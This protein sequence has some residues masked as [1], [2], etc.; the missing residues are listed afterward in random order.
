MTAPGHLGS[1][2]RRAAGSFGSGLRNSRPLVRTL[3]WIPAGGAV[4]LRYH[5]V[6]SDAGWAGE[7][8]QKSLVV[9][10]EIFDLQMALL[11]RRHRIVSVGEIAEAVGEGRPLDHRSVAITFDDG[12]EDNYR[13]AL[14]IL[15]RHGATAT[16]Y[17]TTGAIADRELLWPVR[18]R[19]AV[20]RSDR[21][22]ID[23]KLVGRRP[24]DLS[25]ADAREAAVRLLTGMVKRLPA[26]EADEAVSEILDA[27]G[28]PSGVRDRRVIMSE[29][30][31]R[32]MREAGMTIGAH[33]VNH[34]NLPSLESSDIEKEVGTS[35]STLETILGDEV[36]HF[37]YPDGR[38]GRHCDGRVARIVAEQGFSSAVTSVAG[39]VSG[40]HSRYG[41]PR[42]GIYS[43]HASM[44]RFAADVQYARFERT[45]DQALEEIRSSVPQRRASEGGAA[46]PA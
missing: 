26:R 23:L 18:I 37:A 2:L 42:L 27:C 8:V 15:L 7:Y 39:P 33:T 31:I 45:A 14:P 22:A 24:V 1:G 17:V 34:Y 36:A 5:S 30:E 21:D 6:S 19:Y 11:A 32:E 35:K 44:T 38:T 46:G 29:D 3:S 9:A 40:R 12:Y 4:I 43:R 13:V 10:P 41:I 16:F 20:G 25:T 28:T